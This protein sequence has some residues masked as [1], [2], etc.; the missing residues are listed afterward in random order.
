[1]ES[2]WGLAHVVAH[3]RDAYL[4]IRTS[5]R[6]RCWP[7]HRTV[8]IATGGLRLQHPEVSAGELAAAVRQI[9]RRNKLCY[10]VRSAPAA[11]LGA[12]GNQFPV[13]LKKNLWSRASTKRCYQGNRTKCG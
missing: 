11:K 10:K 12:H 8:A 2:V 3:Q 6:I 4:A 1:M 5:W 7:G 13:R 9:T